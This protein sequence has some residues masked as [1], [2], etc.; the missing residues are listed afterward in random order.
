MT[1]MNPVIVYVGEAQHALA[2]QTALQ[3]LG[4]SLLYPQEMMEA[5]AMQVFYYPDMFIIED[6]GSFDDARGVYAHL[7]SVGMDNILLLTNKPATWGL[8]NGGSVRALPT[9]SSIDTL[10]EAV[11]TMI[12]ADPEKMPM[13]A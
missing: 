3:P 1:R 7:R 12:E 9:Y 10:V 4:W 11:T 13:L 2:L 6:N 8:P 5:L